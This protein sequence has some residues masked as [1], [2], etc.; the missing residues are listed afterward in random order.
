M[1]NSSQNNEERLVQER[2]GESGGKPHG[3][4]ETAATR[5]REEIASKQTG[6]DDQDAEEDVW[7]G[8]YSPKA[9]IGTWLLI[10]VVSIALL[11]AMLA[12]PLSFPIALIL[13]VVIWGLG[14]LRYMSRRLGVHY[15]LSNQRF[16]HQTGI[17]TR[18]TDRMEVIDIDDVSY[19]QGPI[20]RILGVGT[21]QLTGSDRTHPTLSMIGIA[22]VAEVA[23]LLDDIRRTERRRR[24][25]HI[26]SI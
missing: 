23:G 26:E 4:E 14:G 17:L 20:E 24:S 21:I 12:S 9:M 16:I 1:S 7:S 18:Q 22:E 10:G 2:S 8:G 15:Q 19:S 3:G 5:F 11:I 25:L 6:S 13:I